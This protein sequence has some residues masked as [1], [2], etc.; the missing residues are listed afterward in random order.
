V[1][2]VRIELHAA[3]AVTIE[4]VPAY[5]H[6]RDV[7]VDVP[8]LGRLTGDVAWGGNWFFLTQLPGEPLEM[9]NLANLTRATL[10][11]KDALR[12]AGVTGVGGPRSTT[13]RFRSPRARYDSRNFQ[14]CPAPTTARRARALSARWRR[15]TRGQLRSARSGGRRA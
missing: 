5:C 10:R 15:S 7:G 3:A 9:A 1:G 14:M 13:S 6:E 11:I 8:G 2:R 4:N 12:A